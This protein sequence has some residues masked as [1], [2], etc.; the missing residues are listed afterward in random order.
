MLKSEAND[1]VAERF[2]RVMNATRA[3][4]GLTATF[5]W[6]W[7]SGAVVTVG[8]FLIRHATSESAL[9]A[10]IAWPSFRPW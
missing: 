2:T 5:S 3:R 4:S 10:V 6:P 1:S 7:A 8:L 9:Y